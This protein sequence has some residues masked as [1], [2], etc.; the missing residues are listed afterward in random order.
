M[1]IFKKAAL[2]ILTSAVI[3]N[4]SS[5][6]KNAVD[7]QQENQLSLKNK[8]SALASGTSLENLIAYKKSDHQITAGFYRTW[9]DRVVSGNANDPVMTELPDSLDVVIVFTNYTPSDSPYWT[10]LKD[11]YI[12]YLHARGTKVI[13]TGSLT[14]PAGAG[15]NAAG[16][17]AAAKKI[18]DET[19]NKYGL[20]GFDIDIEHNVTGA[21]LTEKT[22]IYTALSAYL[23]PKSGTGKLLTYDTNQDGNTPFFKNVCG[24]IDYVWLQAYG[25]GSSTL[26]NTWNTFSPNIPSKKFVPGFS[27]YEENG[28]PGNY[29]DD[30]LYPQNGTGRAYDY[31]RWQPTGGSKK[32]GVVSYAI[33]RDA[34]L[35]SPHDNTIVHPNF[36]VTKD[37]IKIM[38]P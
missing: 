30:V 35:T 14:M 24:M 9:R 31:A 33:D 11:V 27:F 20:D 21:E 28:Y 16:Y 36:K 38:N 6:K 34:A 2:V 5:C 12:P 18:M 32:G 19:V 1:K 17:A 15:Q 3:V 23:G 26:Q 7:D 8:Q 29:W 25:R 37:L 22:G 4:L 13:I 10:K